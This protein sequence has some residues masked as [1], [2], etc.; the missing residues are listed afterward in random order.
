M[1]RVPLEK[2]KRGEEVVVFIFGEPLID[3][4]ERV[5]VPARSILNRDADKVY[6][7]SIDIDERDA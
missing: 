5:S 4:E 7:R 2:L 1:R 6:G 3:M